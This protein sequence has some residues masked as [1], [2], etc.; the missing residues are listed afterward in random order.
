MKAISI[1][2][3][4]HSGKTTTATALITMLSQL[5][6]QVGSIK[7]IHNT[8][9]RADNEGTN[10]WRHR[11]AGSRR[12]FARGT[13]DTALFFD[14][15]LSFAD[16]LAHLSGDF[17]IIEGMKDLSLP[18]ILCITRQSDLRGAEEKSADDEGLRSDLTV[19]IVVH[20]A[21]CQDDRVL[22][23]RSCGDIP[24]FHLP[25]DT[26]ALLALA[27]GK[28][29]EPL[30]MVDPECCCECGLSCEDM[31]RAII[32]GTRQ[33]NECRMDTS[34]SLGIKVNG[35]PL[36]IVPFIQRLFQ[37]QIEAFIRN[38]KGTEQAD[39]IEITIRRKDD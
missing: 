35:K 15:S 2:G 10:S 32:S 9:F 14:Q 16:M 28:S 1:I 31:M 4:H 3:Y 39:R 21:L 33:R 24:V 34:G 20:P 11:Q 5:G 12:V 18:Q 7:D 25:R 29:V 37:D 17:L 26:K 30:P 22:Q 27:V 23:M 19:A 8:A 38:L 13:K 36:P 6:Y